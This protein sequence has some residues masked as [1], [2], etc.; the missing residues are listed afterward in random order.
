MKFYLVVQL[1]LLSCP[2]IAQEPGFRRVPSDFKVK[3]V[4]ESLVSNMAPVKSQDSLG[5]CYSFAAATVIDTVRCKATGVNCQSL[6]AEKSASTLDLARFGISSDMDPSVHSADSIYGFNGIYEG[7]SPF[8]V[9][10]RLLRTKSYASEKCA[11]FDQIVNKSTSHAQNL[12]MLNASWGRLKQSYSKYKSKEKS[13]PTCAAD[14]ASTAIDDIRQD[15]D[16]KANNTQALKAFAEESYEKFLDKLLVPEEC[17]NPRKML[18]FGS[19]L[20]AEYFPKENQS[21][22]FNE[23]IAVIKN[24]LKADLPLTL[25]FCLDE[26]FSGMAKCQ[27]AHAVVVTGYRKFCKGPNNCREA[28]KI[29][30]S[31]GQQWQKDN[32]DGWV[33]AKDILD[34]SSYNQGMVSW[35]QPEKMGK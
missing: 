6:P 28:L 1:I 17:H 35:I 19:G 13:C 30:N 18:R 7:G 12:Q 4:E 22:Y 14:F 25:G 16:L 10:H 26:P 24:V 34:R 21:N 27:N 32:D 20:K 29:Q 31:W 8:N 11:P 5:I 23:T 15:F 33:D 2:V 3:S 9:L